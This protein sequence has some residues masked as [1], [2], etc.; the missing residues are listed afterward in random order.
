MHG[1]PFANI[2]MVVTVSGPQRLPSNLLI[3]S[4]E[5]G[6]GADLGAEKFSI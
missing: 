4:S 5:A 6:F 3:M 1:G 2:A